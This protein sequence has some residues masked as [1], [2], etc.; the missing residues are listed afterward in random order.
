MTDRP[1][2]TSEMAQPAVRRITLA[3]A[4]E[5]LRRDGQEAYD[6]M[7]ADMV[8]DR[9]SRLERDRAELIE[10]LELCTGNCD[11]VRQLTAVRG[12]GDW[13]DGTTVKQYVDALLARMKETP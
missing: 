3:D 7:A 12:I 5:Y 10:A 8:M 6:Y 9:I 1:T 13:E 11:L 4:V 2:P